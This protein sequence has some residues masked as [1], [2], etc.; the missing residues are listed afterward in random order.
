MGLELEGLIFGSWME[1]CFS[2]FS[3]ANYRSLPP[4]N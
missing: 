4:G 2:T 1:H 3:I